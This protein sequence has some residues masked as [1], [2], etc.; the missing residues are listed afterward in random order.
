M[1]MTEPRPLIVD[2]FSDVVCPWC[3]IGK[4]RLEKALRLVPDIPVEVRWRPFFLNPWIDRAGMDR[5]A[6]L[7]VKFGSVERYNRL[8]A[9]VAAV[10]ADEGLVYR[11][12]L[13]RRQP[14]TIDCHRLVRWASEKGK[15]SEMKERLMEMFFTAGSDL[16]DMRVLLNAAIAAGLDRE[17][18]R[19]KLDSR[20]D[21][22]AVTAEAKEAADSGIDG[23]PTF[24]IGG[25]EMIF[26]AQPAEVIAK[27]IREVAAEHAGQ[28]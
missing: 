24:V 4:R 12:D 26:G 3:Y 2:V 16:T 15:A 9:S 1:V 22:D 19:A 20:I 14:N 8:A 7:K 18:T 17:A 25:S 27:T 6:F 10:A 11:F 5:D 23:V 21:V 28:V 13:L